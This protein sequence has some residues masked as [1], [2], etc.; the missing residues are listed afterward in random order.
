MYVCFFQHHFIIGNI[1]VY[2]LLAVSEHTLNN[3]S[4]EY[5]SLI[6]L[7]GFFVLGDLNSFTWVYH[8]C[9]ALKGSSGPLYQIMASLPK[10][11]FAMQMGLIVVF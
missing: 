7:L 3:I 11:L 5:K 1:T 9:P 6:A 4:Q 10:L 2:F 8:H